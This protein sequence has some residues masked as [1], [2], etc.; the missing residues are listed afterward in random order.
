MRFAMNMGKVDD[1]TIGCDYE[2]VDE[3]HGCTAPVKSLQGMAT[4][5]VGL[6]LAW[7]TAMIPEEWQT[8]KTAYEIRQSMTA[9]LV[10]DDAAIRQSA[11]PHDLEMGSSVGEKADEPCSV[12]RFAIPFS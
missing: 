10:R 2:T 11:H 8:S 6:S 5:E 3:Y 9:L 12:A 1:T 7:S 4:Q